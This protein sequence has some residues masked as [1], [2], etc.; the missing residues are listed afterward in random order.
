MDAL[1]S[2]HV[3]LLDE[4]LVNLWSLVASSERLK[5]DDEVAK[6]LLNLYVLI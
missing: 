5:T 6:V 3:L 1:A 4:D 2:R